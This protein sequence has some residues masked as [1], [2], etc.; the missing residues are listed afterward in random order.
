M[1]KSVMFQKY[2]K[3]SVKPI[4]WKSIYVWTIETGCWEKIVKSGKQIKNLI[5]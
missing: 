1:T 5:L 4:R 3:F 2:A